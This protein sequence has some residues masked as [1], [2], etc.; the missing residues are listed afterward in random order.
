MR[1]SLVAALAAL[2]LAGQAQAADGE[3][4][5]LAAALKRS[6]ASTY[7]GYVFTKVA[8]S[9]PSATATKA[10]CNA[11]FTHRAQ[12]LE[13]VFR[14][15]VTIDRKT[16]GVSWKATSATCTDLVSGKKIRC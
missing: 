12:Q 11:H 2:A 1:L 8:C 6:M 3:S 7:H 13:G 15:A 14:I 16:G 9:I 4:A 10:A 5:K